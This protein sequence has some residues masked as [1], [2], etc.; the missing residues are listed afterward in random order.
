MKNAIIPK[1][2]IP[3]RLN[4]ILSI[5][6]TGTSILLLIIGSK[7]N[8]GWTFALLAF[9]F[10]FIMIPAYSL[11]HE[12]E[13]GILHENKNA[14]YIFGYLLSLMFM[15]PF[16]F[17]QQCHLGH[18][19]RNRTDFEMFDLHYEHQSGTIRSLYLH[20]GRLGFQWI[21]L[22]FS[23]LV[24]L[25]FPRAMTTSVMR[26]D[27]MTEGMLSG[28]YKGT[29]PKIRWESL[30]VVIF[31]VLLVWGLDLAWQNY[32]IMYLVHGFIWSSHN[33]V[34]HA[35]SER[36]IINGAHN[37]K[38]PKWLQ[39]FYLNFNLHLAHHQHPKVPWL[40]LNDFVDHNDPKRISFYTNYL[41]LWKGT[42]LTREPSPVPLEELRNRTT[43]QKP[44]TVEENA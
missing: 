42:V 35:F 6:I 16:T 38:L 18:H 22:P 29:V 1:Y 40:Y 2:S 12:A 7:I 19:K 34:N 4:A 36:D 27:L 32:M 37:H 10:G 8:M 28:L 25:I 11:V 21:L 14:N 44:L 30:G 5:S 9:L 41:R 23:V 13:H 33:Y 17:F 31:H 20:I 3:S 39:R 24:F 43:Y 26:M 15:A